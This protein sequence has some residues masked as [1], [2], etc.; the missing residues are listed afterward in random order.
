MNPDKRLYIRTFG[1]QMNEHDSAKIR[2]MLAPYGYSS[3]DKPED[4]DLI[5]FN[6]CTIREKAHH[7]AMSEIGRALAYKK[8][9]PGLLI[10]VCGCVAQEEKEAIFERYSHVDLIFGPDQIHRLPELIND[11]KTS[12]RS[13]AL[14]LVDDPSKY[15]FLGLKSQ[16]SGLKFQVS[17]FVSIMKGC[18]CACSYCIVPSVRGR[19]V[20]RAEDE[21][22]REINVLATSGTK[23]VVLLGQNVSAYKGHG[24][25]VKGQ[26]LF[27]N[28]LRRVS[29]ET[30]VERIRFV[31]PHPRD[32][33]EDLIREYAENK[34]L[35]PHIH[36][37]VQAGNNDILRKMRR[38]YTRERYIEI[39]DALKKTN[40]GFSITTDLIVGFCGETRGQFEETLDLMRR[41][42]FDSCFA[43]K[44][45]PRPG[46]EA[47]KKFPDD[48][49]LSEKEE[50]LEKLLSLQR[51]MSFA[52]NEA[53]IGSSVS[54]LAAEFDKMNRGMITGRLPDNRVAHFPGKEGHI[55]NIIQLRIVGAYANSLK[56]EIEK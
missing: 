46:T 32:V 23:E 38:G 42:K 5:L 35:M 34:K 4:A 14:E 1:C 45:S 47:F 26:G 53:L 51:E 37:P 3:A 16:V 25:W 17:S 41:V 13:S 50:R 18:N 6:T 15:V 54:V 24:S 7:K 55:G 9:R 30:P 48:V 31:S 21:I 36:L 49:P 8:K 2:N 29:D 12:G 22:I 44:Y 10:G 11:A 20:C 27:S 40:P 39:C 52:S 56:G 28:L 19:E 33:G 43:F